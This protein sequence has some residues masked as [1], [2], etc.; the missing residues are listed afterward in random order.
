M[1]KLVIKL[2]TLATFLVAMN[3]ASSLTPAFAAGGGGGGGGGGDALPRWTRAFLSTFVIPEAVGHKTPQ[4]KKAA[5]SP[6]IDDPDLAQGYPQPMR[7]SSDRSDYTAA[8]EQLKA[9]GHDATR[10][11]PINRLFLSKTWRL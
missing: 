9:L 8:I 3:T 2:G 7:R 1:I 5:S 10:T 4:V 11:W 6:V